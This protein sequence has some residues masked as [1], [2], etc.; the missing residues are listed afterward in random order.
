MTY[1]EWLTSQ[2]EQHRG[3]LRAI[4]YRMLGSATDADDAVQET[5]LRLHRSGAEEIENLGGWLTTV[6]ARICLNTLQ[7]RRREQPLDALPPQP[8][9]PSA[10]PDTEAEQADAVGAAMLVVLNTL[11][12]A[13]RLAFV[14]HDLF[15]MPFDEIAPIL[16]RRPAAARQLASRARRRVRGGGPPDPDRNRQ[17]LVVDAFLAAAKD[18]NFEALLE[19]LD[20]D[21]VLRADRAAVAVAQ[22][23][24]KRGA[25][26]LHPEVHGS[27]AVAEV[28][29]GQA[30]GVQPALIDGRP[31]AAWAPEG[32]PRSIFAMTIMN[33]KITSIEVVVDQPQLRRLDIKIL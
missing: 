3:R 28:F 24:Q 11:T 32:R 25:P 27:A 13:E 18:G 26:P 8:A 30:A 16:D 17:Q 2:F 14:L 33:T 5:W 15:G 31:G 23:N 29:L 4:A 6:V 10:G 21:I 12:P 7:A 1:P 20:P 19:I 9:D 22:A